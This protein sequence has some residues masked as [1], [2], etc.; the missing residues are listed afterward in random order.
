MDNMNEN[1]LK[2]ILESIHLCNSTFFDKKQ[3]KSLS[4]EL[5]FPHIKTI[6]M[7]SFHKGGSMT[8]VSDWVELEKG[9]FTPV[10][11]R[12]VELGY[13]E[14]KSCTDRRKARLI[15][16]EKG[17]AFAQAVKQKHLEVLKNKLSAFTDKE[18]KDFLRALSALH[19]SLIILSEK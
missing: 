8:C 13:V 19:D 9:S 16:T 10:A 5:G 12:L 2:M 11:N 7:L 1:E 17:E 4:D 3:I 14:K 6:M 18:Y 15:L